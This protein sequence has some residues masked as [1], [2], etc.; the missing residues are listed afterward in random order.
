MNH[1]C[2][3]PDKL[4]DNAVEAEVDQWFDGLVLNEETVLQVFPGKELFKTLRN[5][6]AEQYDVDIR[7]SDLRGALTK[8]RLSSDIKTIFKQIAQ[9]KKKP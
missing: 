7:E 8:T 9:G 4:D 1:F 6:V 2:D 3:K 5:L